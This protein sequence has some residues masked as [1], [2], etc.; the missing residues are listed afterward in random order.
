GPDRAAPGAPEPVAAE[1]QDHRR[2]FA[3]TETAPR[4][5]ATERLGHRDHRHGFGAADGIGPTSGTEPRYDRSDGSRHPAPR[6]IQ[7]PPETLA[8]RRA[9]D[10]QR[11]VGPDRCEGTAR[12]EPVELPDHGRRNEAPRQAD[13]TRI[14]LALLHGRHRRGAAGFGAARRVAGTVVVLRGE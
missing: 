1:H 6:D 11:A 9:P 12:T 5:R 13:A 14:A 2:R 3:R 4:T 7:V 8:T 10:G